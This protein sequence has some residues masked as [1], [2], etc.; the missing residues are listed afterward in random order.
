VENA[1]I[2]HNCPD[3]AA[4]QLDTYV[5]TGCAKRVGGTK[6]GKYYIPIASYDP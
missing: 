1:E 6:K 3:D 5:V 2:G 4:R